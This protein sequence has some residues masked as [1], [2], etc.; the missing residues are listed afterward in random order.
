MKKIVFG[1]PPFLLYHSCIT[2]VVISHSPDQKGLNKK[3]SH[4]FRCKPEVRDQ[5]MEMVFERKGLASSFFGG[6]KMSSA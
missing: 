2:E 6:A 3:T 5:G 4:P 1:V